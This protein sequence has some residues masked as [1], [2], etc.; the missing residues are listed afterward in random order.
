MAQIYISST[1]EDLKRHRE[2]VYHRLRQMRHDVIAMEDYVATDQRP[3]ARCLVDVA[4]SDLYIGIFAWR[5]G[6]VPAH[7]SPEQISITELEFRHAKQE[8]KPCF[9]FLL[10]EDYPWPPAHIE[11]GEGGRKLEALRAEFCARYTVSFFRNEDELAGLVGAAV[12]NWNPP[13]PLRE[14]LPTPGPPLRAEP[15][16]GLLVPK[17]CDRL[18]QE[19]AFATQFRDS[20]KAYPRMPQIYFVHGRERECH[21]S[22]IERLAHQIEKHAETNEGEQQGVVPF[23]QMAWPYVGDLPQLQQQLLKLLFDQFAGFYLGEEQSATALSQLPAMARVPFVVI[24]HRIDAAHWN[25]GAREL[26]NW[27]IAYWAKIKI[28]PSRPPQFLIFLSIVYPKSQ[29]DTWWKKWRASKQSDKDQIEREIREI[30][31]ARNADCPCLMLHELS[32]VSPNDVKNWFDQ[33]RLN[34]ILSENTQDD[35][36]AKLFTTDDGLKVEFKSMADIEDG[37]QC[38]V[39]CLRESHA[40]QKAELKRMADLEQELQCIVGCLQK[41]R[42]KGKL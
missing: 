11:R 37:L 15:N 41:S 12:H 39:G 3:V 42:E 29:P 19:T 17:T 35:L 27:Y 6:H 4:D 38:I 20:L 40:R 21:D 7:S 23:K 26:L 22:F 18:P 2:K 31:L 24:Q 36:L 14:A 32:S 5:Y 13:P 8:G 28:A 9:I 10:A 34:L 16:L 1:Y 30:S 33:H 25:R